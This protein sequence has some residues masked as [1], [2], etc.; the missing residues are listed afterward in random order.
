MKILITG[1]ASGVGNALTKNLQQHNVIGLTRQQLDLSDINAVVKYEIGMCDVLINCAATD[2]GGKIDFV[3][4]DTSHVVDILTTNL[5]SPLVLSKHALANNP[6]CKIVNITSTNNNRYYPNDLAY[7]LSKKSLAN[8]GSMLKIEYPDIQYL[9]IRLGLTKPNF[10]NN[11]YRCNQERFN[12][13]YAFR[14]LTVEQV[15]SKIIDV[16]FDS[17]INLI[18]ISP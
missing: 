9:E 4:H 5:L 1:A 10:N 8:L 2:I 14:H 6:N 13:V 18:E 12:D 7:S 11:R 15:V 3:N 17:S 16:L